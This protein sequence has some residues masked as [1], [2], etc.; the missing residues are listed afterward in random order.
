MV[1]GPTDG[2]LHRREIAEFPGAEG[3][4][5]TDLI[6]AGPSVPSHVGIEDGHLVWSDLR[7]QTSSTA[8][9][10]DDFLKIDDGDELGVIEFAS[11]YGTLDLCEHDLPFLHQPE[12]EPLQT[13]PLETWYFHADRARAL[14]TWAASNAVNPPRPGTY[15]DH[16]AALGRWPLGGKIV[17]LVTA[18]GSERGWSEVAR[19]Q[20][21]LR[22]LVNQWMVLGDVRPALDPFPG[23]MATILL[24]STTT[25]GVLGTQIATAISRA[26]E[27]WTCTICG[28]PYFRGSR[29][30]NAGQRNV[31]GRQECQRGAAKERK[32]DSRRASRVDSPELTE[33]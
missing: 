16:V 21:M 24:S 10:L 4:V 1:N 32:R 23:S 27:I 17:E 5:G 3:L 11:R 26:R 31:C 18:A 19:D 29:K 25:Y 9:A 20:L 8:G 28:F 30:P 2:H 33:P 7:A 14:L 12:C 15:A 22:L 13:E 6:P